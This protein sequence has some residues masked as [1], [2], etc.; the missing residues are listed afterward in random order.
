MIKKTLPIGSREQKPLQSG[1]E[2]VADV[3]EHHVDSAVRLIK[4]TT[5]SVLQEMALKPEQLGYQNADALAETMAFAL[6]PT[7]VGQELT[8]R[9]QEAY[10]RIQVKDRIGR[11][12]KKIDAIKTAVALV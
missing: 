1:T 10:I 11:I 6:G 8:Q 7:A 5:A 3:S 2:L 4:T 12:L 9:E